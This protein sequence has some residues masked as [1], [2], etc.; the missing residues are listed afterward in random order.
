MFRGSPGPLVPLGQESGQTKRQAPETK[1]DLFTDPALQATHPPRTLS[2]TSLSQST[3]H[4]HELLETTFSQNEKGGMGA[5]NKGAVR[6]PDARLP[7]GE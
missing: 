7:V 6:S 5:T 2:E 3:D 4:I 1:T